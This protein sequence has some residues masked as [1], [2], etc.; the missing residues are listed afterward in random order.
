MWLIAFKRLIAALPTALVGS[1]L[2]FALVHVIPGGA[3]EAIAG[4]D[5]SPEVIAKLNEELGLN[6]P[7]HVQFGSWFWRVAQGDFGTSLV[8]NRSIAEDILHRLP[9]TLELAAVGLMIALLVGV[10]LGVLAAVWRGRLLDTGI[11]SLAGIGLAV[12][13]FW[14]AM[15]AVN[16]FALRL[17]WVPAIGV[18]PVSQGLLE[19][20]QSIV[21]PCLT[22]GSGAAAAVARFARSGMIEALKSPYIRTARAIG[23]APLPLYA[24]FALKNA[25]IPVL[26]VLG[27]IAGTLIGGA[28]LVEQVFVIPGLGAMLVTGVLQKDFPAVQGVALVLTFAVIA[29]NLL[30]DIGCASLDPRIR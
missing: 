19:H 21:L 15:L 12:P 16:L 5:G 10:P 17:A 28:I 22:L 18:A 7:L 4:P 13:E 6:R 2:I 29:I 14:L 3:A 30:V 27:I 25:L 26:T 11:N 8:D 23:M 20:L 9:L 1:V 24:R